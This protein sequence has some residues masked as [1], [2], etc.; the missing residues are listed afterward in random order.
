MRRESKEST[1]EREIVPTTKVGMAAAVSEWVSDESRDS[2]EFV[3][4]S[5]GATLAYASRSVSDELLRLLSAPDS[6]T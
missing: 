1:P 3:D 4:E 2:V 5:D 6:G